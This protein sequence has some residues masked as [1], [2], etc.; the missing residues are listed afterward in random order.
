MKPKAY[1]DTV[2]ILFKKKPPNKL[3]NDLKRNCRKAPRLHPTKER[4][5]HGYKWKLSVHVPTRQAMECLARLPDALV[6]ELHVAFDLPASDVN[7]AFALQELIESQ[8]WI[9]SARAFGC[10]R[11]R[12][13]F[14]SGLPKWDA[15]R[16]C[17]YSDKPSRHNGGPVCHVEL[18]FRGANQVR[19]VGLLDIGDI[20]EL[21]PAAIVGRF[22]Q[23]RRLSLRKL[24]RM[25][26][27]RPLLSTANEDRRAGFLA[28]ADA[29]AQFA[30]WANLILLEAVRWYCIEYGIN[31]RRA[32]RRS[33][34]YIANVTNLDVFA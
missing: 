23:L 8:L 22:L 26:G 20:T 15:L 18:R 30:P 11:F 32:L 13:T 29:T 17:I 31:I 19:R 3:F 21:D 7:A 2:C 10:R 34:D 25:F 16:I 4:G 28:A 12:Q 9:A 6:N 5:S 14:Y 33:S 27:G 1:I 24:G